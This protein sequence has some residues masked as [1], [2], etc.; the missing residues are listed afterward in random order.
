M[1]IGSLDMALLSKRDHL[2]I[3]CL[4]VQHIKFVFIVK[5]LEK[6]VQHLA[7]ETTTVKFQAVLGT[8]QG[9]MYACV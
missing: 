9:R 8:L 5:V 6:E 1:P 2:Q 7:N 3:F 4:A